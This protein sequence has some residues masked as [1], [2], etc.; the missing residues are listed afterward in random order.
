[1]AKA[2]Y[3]KDPDFAKKFDFDL[4]K[5]LHIKLF[6]KTKNEL[7]II[8]YRMNLSLQ[9]IFEFL[10]KAIINEDPHIIK[11][12]NQYKIDKENQ[13]IKLSESD[14]D[15]LFEALDKNNPLRDENDNSNNS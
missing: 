9:E 1:M 14:A 3:L 6:T 12:L 4:R 11:L 15:E 10:A 7:K 8:A 2:K 13:A 5:H